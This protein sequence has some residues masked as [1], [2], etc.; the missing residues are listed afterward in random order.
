MWS[1]LCRFFTRVVNI[2]SST[3]ALDGRTARTATAKLLGDKIQRRLTS[4]LTAIVVAD[5]T[6]IYTACSVTISI[7]QEVRNVDRMWYAVRIE[8]R[9]KSFFKSIILHELVRKVSKR[10][11]KCCSVI[12][13]SNRVIF[14]SQ[15]IAGS[16]NQ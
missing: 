4:M 16:S 14:V 1:N 11:H 15:L 2:Q 9:I 7:Y 10:T 13:I 6:K 8:C 12:S 5:E 3:T